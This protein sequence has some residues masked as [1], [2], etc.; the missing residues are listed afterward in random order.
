M[1]LGS[2]FGSND[3]P[4]AVAST[5][6]AKAGVI[7]VTSAGNSGPS[8]YITGSPGT[9][10]GAISTAAIDPSPSFPA[11]TITIP[12]GPMTAVNA[13]EFTLPPTATYT[14]KTIVDNP[15]RRPTVDGV[16]RLTS[17]S[18]GVRRPAARR[19]RSPSSSAATAPASRRRSS[20]RRPEPPRS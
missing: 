4:S 7:V 2:P 17:R 12:S 13:N 19:T 8:Q 5:N 3:D 10:E 9:G 20:A 14:V 11:A 16:A 15:S 18:A 1:S 6:A